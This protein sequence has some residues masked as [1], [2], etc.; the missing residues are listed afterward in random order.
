MYTLSSLLCVIITQ[1]AQKAFFYGE[2]IHLKAAHYVG[3]AK[4][5][6]FNAPFQSPL[7]SKRWDVNLTSRYIA[8]PIIL[9][10]IWPRKT[11]LRYIFVHNTQVHFSYIKEGAY[12]RYKIIK[13]IK[14]I[15]YETSKRPLTKT[16]S[17]KSGI[18]GW[19]KMFDIADIFTCVAI[20]IVTPILIQEKGINQVHCGTVLSA[21]DLTKL[22]ICMMWFMAA[23]ETKTFENIDQRVIVQIDKST[24]GRKLLCSNYF[25]LLELIDRSTCIEIKLL[26]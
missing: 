21:F 5:L 18:R 1:H 7:S 25:R 12:V 6:F 17:Q 26:I 2:L 22:R 24:P 16:D 20:C 11:Y 10:S 13:V 23:N 8:S 14:G 3:K 4:T 9:L 15:T 19:I